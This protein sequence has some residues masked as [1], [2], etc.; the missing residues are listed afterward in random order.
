MKMLLEKEKEKVEKKEEVDHSGMERFATVISESFTAAQKPLIDA[1]LTRQNGTAKIMKPVR[2]P[3]WTKNMTLEVYI[4]ALEVWVT[5]NREMPELVKYQEVLETLKQNKE[6]S[7]LE[8][9]IGKHVF[10][11]LDTVERQTITQ[12]IA[13]L[14]TK[15]GKTNSDSQKQFTANTAILFYSSADYKIILSSTFL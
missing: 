8:E 14:K 13:I 5:Q 11:A 9:Y 7:G 10:S 4:K 15:Y 2:P 12:L 6:I 1:I 3:A